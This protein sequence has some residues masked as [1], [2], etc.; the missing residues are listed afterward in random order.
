MHWLGSKR[1]N[2][3]ISEVMA[4]NM[5]STT[6]GTNE[7]KCSALIALF[8]VQYGHLPPRRVIPLPGRNTR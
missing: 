6:G 5:I 1:R 3:A 4:L 2:V 7:V 8:D